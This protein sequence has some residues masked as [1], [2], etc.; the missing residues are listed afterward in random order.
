ML[1]GQSS[2]E[3]AYGSVASLC[4]GECV[5]DAFADQDDALRSGRARDAGFCE[6]G[7]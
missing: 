7:R 1:I 6:P 5:R 3:H 4:C 2:A